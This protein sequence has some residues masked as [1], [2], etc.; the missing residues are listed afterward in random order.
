MEKKQYRYRNEKVAKSTPYGYYVVDEYN[1]P[2]W[3]IE[4]SQD[5]ELIQEP[6]KK[7]WTILQFER[8]DKLTS[9]QK[10]WSMQSNG[11]YI[12]SGTCG[13]KDTGCGLKAIMEIGQCVKNGAFIIYQIRRES[14]GSIWTVGDKIDQKGHMS[15]KP[16]TISKFSI[17]DQYIGGMSVQTETGGCYS[18]MDIEHWTV[19]VPVEPTWVIESVLLERSGNTQKVKDGIVMMAADEHEPIK[20][21]ERN[22][23]RNTNNALLLVTGK[24]GR[25]KWSIQSA[26]VNK[27]SPVISISDWITA[28]CTHMGNTPM[29]VE[30]FVVN[31]RNNLLVKTR[32]FRTHGV[33]IENCRKVDAPVEKKQKLVECGPGTKYIVKLTEGQIEKLQTFL[34]GGVIY[35]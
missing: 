10:Y 25:E 24:G 4:N 35:W 20:Y 7:E 5:W 2:D 29:Q 32:Q 3:I 15:S 31:D 8:V 6:E 30:G 18:I 28:E 34:Q 14:D 23:R 16:V 27:N 11:T 17:S 9:S 19:P 13:G 22:D 26:R 12:P 21:Y 1:V 33:S